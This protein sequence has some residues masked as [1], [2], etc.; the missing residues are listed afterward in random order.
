MLLM[1]ARK[2]MSPL[3]ATVLLIAFAVALG[4]MIMNWSTDDALPE[5]TPTGQVALCEDVHIGI[6]QASSGDSSFCY[7][8][9]VVKFDVENAGPAA[10]A[11]LQLRVIDTNLE[12]TEVDVPKSTIAAGETYQGVSSMVIDGKVHAEIIPYVMQQG[13]QQYCV[14]QKIVHDGLPP[15]A[16]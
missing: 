1:Y 2:A 13:S 15:C 14:K 6:A 4:A 5:K 7:D 3:I 16:E 8:E 12:L 10:V 11:G 9:G